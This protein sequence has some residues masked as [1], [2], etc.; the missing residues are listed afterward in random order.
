LR[1]ASKLKVSVWCPFVPGTSLIIAAP[2]TFPDKTQPPLA[3]EL[4]GDSSGLQKE[5]FGWRMF[6][7][8]F[9]GIVSEVDREKLRAMLL[10]GLNINIAPKKRSVTVLRTFLDEA[11]RILRE[12]SAEWTGSQSPPNDDDE[13]RRVNPLLAL[14]THMSWLAEV[15]E[16]HPNAS[17]T[18]R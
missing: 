9:G 8:P 12:E 11:N 4:N 17:I 16:E 7:D 2:D 1:E 15:Y 18:V 14:V 10:E 5:V 3:Q 13:E 6:E